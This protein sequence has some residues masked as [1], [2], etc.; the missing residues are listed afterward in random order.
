M[1]SI[2]IFTYSTKPR[3]SVVHAAALAEALHSLGHEVT[4][5]ALS[6]E[7]DEFFREV[8]C[9]LRLILAGPAPSAGDELVKQRVAE[10]SAGLRALAPRHDIYHA[11]DCLVASA[12]LDAR[13]FGVGPIVR[14]VHHVEAFMNPYLAECQRRSIEEADL[15][16]S[17][18]AL[19]RREVKSGFSRQSG[20]VQN[21]VDLERFAVRSAS[22]E[23]EVNARFGLQADDLLVLS[24]GGV[25]ERKNSLRSLEAVALAHAVERRLRWLI[26]GGASIFDHSEYGRRFDARLSELSP[27]LCTRIL[28]TGTISEVELG[29]LYQRSDVLLCPSEK[30][31]FALCVLEAL[32]TRTAVIA[33]AR[34]PFTEYLSSES[35]RLVDPESVVEISA[36]LSRLLADGEQRSRLAERGQKLCERYSWRKSAEQHVRQ[37]R[38]LGRG[39][40]A[41]LRANA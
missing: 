22:Y 35:A 38:A 16:L 14:T 25:E 24:V 5:Y 17:V 41:L 29:A 37:Y 34:A 33:S 13:A 4:L 1:L 23:R 40:D 9:P 30:E 31:G 7:G 6:K 20:L 2:G 15:V 3:G 36:A 27:E 26:V 12:L 39:R 32:A 21:G 18:S 11:E 28:R 19:T 8:R 10:L